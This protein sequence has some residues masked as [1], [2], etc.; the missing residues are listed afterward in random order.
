MK[1][2]G[3]TQQGGLLAAWRVEGLWWDLVHKA[4]AGKTQKAEIEDFPRPAQDQKDL[5]GASF[6]RFLSKAQAMWI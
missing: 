5:E 3:G 2:C 1:A 6:L 4:K